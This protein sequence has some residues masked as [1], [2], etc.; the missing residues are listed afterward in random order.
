MKKKRPQKINIDGKREDAGTILWIDDMFLLVEA[1]ERLADEK[2]VISNQR[3]SRCA[4]V[5]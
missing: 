2:S 1:E 5:T 4:D 3:S